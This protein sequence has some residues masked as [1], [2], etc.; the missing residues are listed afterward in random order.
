MKKVARVL[1]FLLALFTGVQA[2]ADDPKWFP[3]EQV[4]DFP[5]GKTF[6][7]GDILIADGPV[8]CSFTFKNVAAFPIVIHNIISSCG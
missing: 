1:V 5:E 3:E 4:V 2:L 8:K 7:F 6:D